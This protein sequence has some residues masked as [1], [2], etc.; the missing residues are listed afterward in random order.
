MT[1]NH[2]KFVV[3]GDGMC[4]KCVF[5]RRSGKEFRGRFGPPRIAPTFPAAAPGS[6]PGWASEGVASEADYQ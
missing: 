3:T 1:G 6:G 4:E 5:S 2:E